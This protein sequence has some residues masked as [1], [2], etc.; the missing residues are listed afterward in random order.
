MSLDEGDDMSN[1]MAGMD[2][3]AGMMG[4]AGANPMA[5]NTD[6]SAEGKKEAGKIL[7]LNLY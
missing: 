3:M 4:G 6:L 5:P 2:P 7:F 1:P